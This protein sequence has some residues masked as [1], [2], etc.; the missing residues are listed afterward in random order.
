MCYLKRL[1]NFLIIKKK[2]WFNPMLFALIIF[3]FLTIISKG[4]DFAPLIYSIF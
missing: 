3:S 1:W 2:Y 4:S